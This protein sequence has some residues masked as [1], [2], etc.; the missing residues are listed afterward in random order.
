MLIHVVSVLV[1]GLA[2]RVALPWS[3]ATQHAACAV[4]SLQLPETVHYRGS[5][6]FSDS[7]GSYFTRQEQETLP[8]CMVRP[9][10]AGQVARVVS[11]M[12]HFLVVGGQFA[13]RSGGHGPFFGGSNLENGVV[14]DLGLL[15][16]VQVSD[17]RSS[18]NLGPGSRWRRVWQ[19]LDPLEITVAGGRDAGVGVGGYLLGGGMS[20]LGPLLGWGCESVLEY[21]VVLASGEIV[22]V[23]EKSHPD[24]F[25]ALK[26]GSN[27]FGIVT[28]F[29]MKTY[30]LGKFWGGFVAHPSTALDKQAAAFSDFM[31]SDPFDSHAAIFQSYGYV[32]NYSVIS[33]GLWYTK[34]VEHPKPLELL[35][36]KDT[37]VHSTLRMDNMSSFAAETGSFQTYDNRSVALLLWSS[38]DEANTHSKQTNLVH[39]FICSLT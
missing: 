15:D 24:L 5:T 3:N 10:S 17:D 23:N 39:H 25:L 36:D 30:P 16:Q 4:L 21:E 19:V 9:S 12:R 14:V 11:T 29:T 26:G 8:L 35:S 27:N 32:S 18:V 6:P 2:L 28:R 38:C 33:N 1:L 7:V 22:T 20:Y 31:G 34:P 37:A 13:V